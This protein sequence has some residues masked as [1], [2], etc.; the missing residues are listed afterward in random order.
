MGAF[1]CLGGAIWIDEA[2]SLKSV[3]GLMILVCAWASYQCDNQI[4]QIQRALHELYNTTDEDIDLITV[5]SLQYLTEESLFNII[6][7]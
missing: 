6:K 1:F 4:E 5:E 7:G 3:L 2:N